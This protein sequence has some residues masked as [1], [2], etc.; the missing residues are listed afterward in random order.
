M[1]DLQVRKPGE[2]ERR[3]AKASVGNEVRRVGS[4]KC[5][6]C[7]IPGPDRHCNAGNDSNNGLQNNESPSRLKVIGEKCPNPDYLLLL[8]ILEL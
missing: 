7:R 8:F 3:G 1:T 5:D 6:R 4:R 2:N